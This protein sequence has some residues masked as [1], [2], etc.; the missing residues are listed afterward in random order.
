[1]LKKVGL[2]L[3][4]IVAALLVIGALMPT[5]KCGEVGYRPKLT[6]ACRA[7]S[8]QQE[9]TYCGEDERRDIQCASATF[10]DDR[11]AVAEATRRDLETR[12]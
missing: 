8:S 2:S 5:P 9:A 4:G 7:A 12:N 10:A 1:M 3:L 6:A 11:R